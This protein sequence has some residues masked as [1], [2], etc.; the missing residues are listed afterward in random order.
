MGLEILLE[1][2]VLRSLAVSSATAKHD[3]NNNCYHEYNYES[4][5]QCPQL[6]ARAI[7]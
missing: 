2:M 6:I 4:Y 5:Q 3:E 1:F 7:G